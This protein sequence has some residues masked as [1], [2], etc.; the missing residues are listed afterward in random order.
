MVLKK[1]FKK[2]S[3]LLPADQKKKDEIF[4]LAKAGLAIAELE[5]LGVS[6]KIISV[7]EENCG[8]IYLEQLLNM[9][10]DQVLGMSSMGEAGL[11]NLK[12]AF[13]KIFELSSQIEK[14]NKGSDRIENYKKKI[15]QKN[16]L[17]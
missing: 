17:A 10:D 14:W 3:C 4:R 2:M 15:N 11:K 13:E 8:A 16:F 6:T 12:L 9:R 7:I 1:I 5:Y